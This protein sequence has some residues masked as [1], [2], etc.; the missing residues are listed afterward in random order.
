ENDVLYAVVEQNFVK[1]N[2]KTD[3]QL[4]REFM[5][6]NDFLNTRNNDYMNNKLGVI[7][8]DLHDENVLTQDDIL[9]FIDTVFYVLKK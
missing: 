8:E 1:A 9:F 3:L 6:A 7:L 5:K 2:Q 4:V